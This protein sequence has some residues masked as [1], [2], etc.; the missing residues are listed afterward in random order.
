MRKM[1]A[2]ILAA[3]KGTRMKSELPKVLHCLGHKPMAQYVIDSAR[4]AGIDDICV[5]VGHGA[6]QVKEALGPDIFYALQEPQ[7]GTGHALKQAIPCCSPDAESFIVLCGD[8]PLLTPETLKSLRDYFESTKAA[9]TVMSAVL[10]EGGAYGRIIRDSQGSLSAIVEARDATPEQAAI[11]EI[12][13]GVYCFDSKYLLK[14][15]DTIK[16]NNAQGEYYLTDLISVIREQGGLVNAYI[17]RE[18][19]EIGGV[20][21]RCQLAEAASVLR[22]RRNRQLMLSG[23]TMVDPSTV[24]IDDNVEIGVDCL[25][26]PNVY[27]EGPCRIGSGC[28]IGPSVKI[29]ASNIG[30]NCEIGPFCYIRPGTVLDDKVKAGHFVE[31][32]K[33]HIGHGSKVPHLSYIGDTTVGRDVNIGCGTITC[34]YNGKQK[35]ATIIEDEAFIGSNTNLVAPVKV[36]RRST[37]GAGSTITED[38]PADTLALGRGR[39]RNIPGW[40]EKKDPRYAKKDEK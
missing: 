31:I 28:H 5:V 39:Q 2:V 25:I 1:S 9:C 18:A 11:R 24:Y 38:V 16:P 23:I 4:S 10:P 12:N 26:E 3:G 37:V 20:N 32:K 8:T 14:V 19:A 36:G 13:S 15:I 35:F 17:C 30:D 29:V 22:K 27:I 6:E 33:S 7:L 40:T 34:N 21:D